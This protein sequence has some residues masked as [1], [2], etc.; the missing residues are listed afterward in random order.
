[1]HE[2]RTGVSPAERF[3]EQ[4]MQRERR[5]PFFSAYH[6]SDL[7]E[8]VVDYVGKMICGQVVGTFVKDLVVKDR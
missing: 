6:V 3:V 2:I 5:Q 1:M 7:H 8:V 4:Y